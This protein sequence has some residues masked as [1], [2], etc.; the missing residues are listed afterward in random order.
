MG[1]AG[2]AS[3]CDALGGVVRAALPSL[4]AWSRRAAAGPRQQ[5]RA[6]IL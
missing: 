4:V 3:R 6:I 2:L 5:Y 1:G